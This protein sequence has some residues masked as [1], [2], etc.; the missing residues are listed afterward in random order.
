[1]M[2]SSSLLWKS[3]F[4]KNKLRFNLFSRTKFPFT[5]LT[6]STTG[7]VSTPPPKKHGGLKDS[8]RIFTN[9]YR[10]GD[11]FI[12]GALKRV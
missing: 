5:T 3:N 9:L 2:K 11:P 10:D 6:P 1:M 8:D 7:G 12:E 4:L